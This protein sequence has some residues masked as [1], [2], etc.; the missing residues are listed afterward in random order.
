[1]SHTRSNGFLVIIK[2]FFVVWSAWYS[3]T[4]E[5]FAQ[6]Q[7]NR[8]RRE[9]IVGDLV[10]RTDLRDLKIH[11]R[12]GMTSISGD[13]N[14]KPFTVFSRSSKGV[15]LRF[16]HSQSLDDFNPNTVR[17]KLFETERA[18]ITA[19]ILDEVDVAVL[20]SEASAI[21]VR[22]SNNRI[23]P[24]PLQMEPNTVKLVIYNHRNPLFE[25][26]KIRAAISYGIDHDYIIKKI[27]LGGKASIA[28]GP[29]DDASPVYNSGMNSY[30]YNPKLALQILG[31]A[32]WHDTNRDGIL[33]KNGVPFVMGLYYQKGLRLDE[34][35]S[36]IIKI[37][38]IKIG[39]DVKPKPLSKEQI[40]NHLSTKDFEAILMDHVF[41]DNV[42]SLSEFF[43]IA[44]QKNY[45]GYHSNTFEN[46]LKFYRDSEDR[47]RRKTLIKSMQSVINQDQPVTFL[48][49]KWLTHYLVNVEKF[50]NFRYTEGADRGKI[51][52]FEEWIFKNSN[53]R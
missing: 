49:F 33:E 45:M 14:G 50:E 18:L 13:G 32:G 3:P 1:M 15:V 5:L 22:K 47:D 11:T 7:N 38:L 21:E 4:I 40:N 12:Q 46:Y 23:L 37:N 10:G 52:P 44:G 35:I 8:F 29:F 17:I 26:P 31:E 36:R 6:E 39:I 48:Y 20:E 25:S 34:A 42:E 19:L 43:S 53:N 9:I 28:K 27:I 30:K 2:I 24:L 16:Y 51:R 41:A